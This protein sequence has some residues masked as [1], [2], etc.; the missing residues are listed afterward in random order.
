MGYVS[1]WMGDH[2]SAL[3]VFLVALQLTLLD[4]NPFRPCY[5][6]IYNYVLH[7]LQTFVSKTLWTFP[8]ARM[9]W[10]WCNQPHLDGLIWVSASTHRTLVLMDAG[11]T[12]CIS[13]ITCVLAKESANLR[14]HSH[15][16][17]VVWDILCMVK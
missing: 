13:W 3:L 11:P 6:L 8:A 14:W 7:F 17:I 4:Q 16:I 12:S 15:S 5:S 1:T 10:S 2:F 9:K